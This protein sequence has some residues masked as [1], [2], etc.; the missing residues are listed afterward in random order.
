[1]PAVSD[2][3]ADEDAGVESLVAGVDDEHPLTS[4]Q[5]TVRTAAIPRDQPS[6]MPPS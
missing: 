1:V 3:E 5:V 4:V 2:G 6:A